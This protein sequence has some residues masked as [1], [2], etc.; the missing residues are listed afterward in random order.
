MLAVVNVYIVFYII[1]ILIND[2][3]RWS[4]LKPGEFQ[5]LVVIYTRVLG[6]GRCVIYY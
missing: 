3:R 1:F 5:L 6:A 2:S 4:S